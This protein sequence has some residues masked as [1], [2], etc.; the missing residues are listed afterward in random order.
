LFTCFSIS[1]KLHNTD[2]NLSNFCK[3]VSERLHHHTDIFN[4][5]SGVALG[6]D[7]IACFS[8]KYCSYLAFSSAVF[9][10]CGLNVVLLKD[11]QSDCDN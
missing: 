6:S 3:D 5:S 11:D 9:I 7:K 4:I 2:W 10:F 1:T 8:F